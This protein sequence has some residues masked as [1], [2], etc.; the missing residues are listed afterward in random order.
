L[1]LL[2]A[3]AGLFLYLRGRQALL[4]IGVVGMASAAGLASLLLFYHTQ[5]VLDHFIASTSIQTAAAGNY[6]TLAGR[7]LSWVRGLTNLGSDPSVV[8]FWL[9]ILAYG[10]VAWLK[11]FGARVKPAV[12]GTIASFIFAVAVYTAGK[13]PV[14]Y[15]WMAYI[16]SAIAWGLMWENFPSRPGFVT[17]R[18]LLLVTAILVGAIGFP[19]R[20][21]LT[22]MQWRERDYAP[23]RA[24][25][26]R[27]ITKTDCVYADLQGYYAVKPIA[28]TILLPPYNEVMSPMEK[29]QITCLFI[30]PRNIAD[31]TNFLGGKWVDTGEFVAPELGKPSFGAVKYDL[32][33]W[34]RAGI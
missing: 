16:P 21:G 24:L 31:V 11:G 28:G 8:F 17:G 12:V 15:A 3:A 26:Q 33:V 9:V 27:T 22:A 10:G 32:R 4:E 23:V 19:L 1:P 29:G 34:R 7:I 30:N 18:R 25:A 2:V 13:F 20:L 6:G 14:Y 5:G